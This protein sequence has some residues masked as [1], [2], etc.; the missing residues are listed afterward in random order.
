M[1]A[2][3]DHVLDA[4]AQGRGATPSPRPSPTTRRRA[5]ATL[6]PQAALTYGATYTVTVKGG[7]R[8][9][10]RPRREPARRRRRRWSFTTEAS[11][12][13][14][15]VV[16]STANPFGSYL[17]EILRNEG[18]N[19]FTT[20]DVA[21][22]S[23]ALL[24]G[25]D[26]VLLGETPLTAGQVTTLDGWV[27]GGGNL[28]AMRPDKQLA[29]LLGLTD[30]GRDARERLPAGRH[31]RGARRR[32]RRQHDPVPRH[33]RPLHAERRDRG[34]DALLERD[35]GDDEPGRDAA[36]GR[37]ERRPGGGVHVRPRPLG[38]LHAPGQPGLGRPGARRRRRDPPRRPVL[39]R[40]GRRLQ[41][42]WLDTNKI[43]IP[44]A[45]EQQRLLVNLITLM[46][47]DKMPLPRFWYLPRG[48]KAVVVMSG[49]DHSPAKRP[50]APRPLRPLQGAQPG[51]LRRRQLGVRPLDLATS[52]RTATLTNAQA[53]LHRGR[54]RG[55]AAPARSARA[56][57][58]A[59]SGTSSRR[60]STRSSASSGASTR[61]P[62]AGLEPHPLRLL[63]RLGV[64]REGR[65]RPRDPAG[66]ELLPLPGA[67]DRR[68]ARLHERR[69]LPDA[70]RRP[71]RDA[72]RRLPAEH[73]H[74]RRVGQTLSSDR[75][76]RCSTTRSA[77]TATT[78][79]S[80]RT[81]TPTTRRRT[82]ARRRSSP[83]AQA[84][85]VPVI[86]YKQ[87]LD[88]VDGRNSS[89]IRGLSW[90]AGT[91]HLHHDRRAGANGLQTMLPIQGRRARSPASAA[92]ARP[93][94][95]RVDDQ[96]HP[97][98]VLHRRHRHLPGAL[99]LSR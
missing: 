61:A 64:E 23:P 3:L 78:A 7:A 65:A 75:S 30:A 21:F 93:C 14:V 80:A 20:I 55:R 98:R 43:A 16:G 89:T 46:E 40:Q 1:T 88:W 66:R 94:R 25:F 2:E 52:T 79:R 32:D 48:E 56:R 84:R 85:S 86:S 34:R 35:D 33:G 91:L 28:I 19:A 8:R 45:D 70:L 42:D 26:V 44:Q 83:S 76:T 99:R 10:D 27:N 81:C 92:A 60:P 9:R 62:G 72:D 49:D 73:E 97:V 15:L 53:T 82:P 57:R 22:L 24:S 4:S 51:R 47:R 71:R 63:A 41:P 58:R 77:R 87:L 18:L 39:R 96:G 50:A 37:L 31:G 54:L 95:T 38:R 90:N 13:Q 17:G 29:G 6:T 12:P 59:D 5:T 69:R 74:D 11:P 67:L 36:L 68:E